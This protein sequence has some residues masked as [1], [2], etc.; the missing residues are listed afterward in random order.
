M[1]HGSTSDVNPTEVIIV[2][3]SSCGGALQMEHAAAMGYSRWLFYLVQ[4]MGLNK[5][6]CETDG[7]SIY[8]QQ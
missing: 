4:A 6:I 8:N 5:V 2:I 3:T 7:S 1:K